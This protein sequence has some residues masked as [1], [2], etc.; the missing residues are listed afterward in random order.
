[1][2]D[3]VLYSFRRCP[4]AMRARFAIFYSQQKVELREVVLKNKPEQ[5]LSA[6]AK[7]TV[8]VLVLGQRVIDESLDIMLWALRKNDPD[9]W[10]EGLEEQL[11]FIATNDQTF[12][13]WLDKYKYADRF[14]EQDSTFYRDQ[15]CEFLQV[16]EAKLTDQSYLFANQPRLV[17]AAIFPFIRQFAGVDK[18]WFESSPYVRTRDWLKLHLDS[19]PFLSIMNKYPAWS[20]SNTKLY[21]PEELV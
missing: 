4:Y 5:L 18:K 15:C 8:P 9:Q 3:S 12:K 17:D 2:S 13:A 20:S 6:S 1:M 14:P 7:G 16:L 19:A 10:L 11:E 21:F